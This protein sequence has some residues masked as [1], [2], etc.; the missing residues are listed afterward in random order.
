[1]NGIPWPA[2]KTFG[3]LTPAQ[4][5]AAVARAARRLEDELTRNADA[6]SA[7]LGKP[8]PGEEARPGLIMLNL[9][10]FQAA[11]IDHGLSV[12]ETDG[13]PEWGRLDYYGR[14]DRKGRRA[15]WLAVQRDQDVLDA[16]LWRLT[17]IRDIWA[18][19]AADDAL[20]ARGAESLSGLILVFTEAA[21]G[22]EAFSPRA[23]RW[24]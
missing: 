17:S 3:Q 24:I 11:E 2:G 5:H 22:P 12:D 14:R 4:Q 10:P 13:N 16:A 18:D 6:L 15:A 19:N 20:S 21:G 9:T 8:L 1:M 23:R 7:I